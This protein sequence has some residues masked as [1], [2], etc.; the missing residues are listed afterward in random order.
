MKKNIFLALVFCCV[1]NNACVSTPDPRQEII[2]VFH[3]QVELDID[4]DTALHKGKGV[5]SGKSQIELRIELES[6]H[7][8]VFIPKLYQAE[9]LFCKNKDKVRGCA[10][11]S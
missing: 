5:K 7:E 4:F 3:K 6:Y 11:L 8:D 2:D 1:I 10:N 9:G